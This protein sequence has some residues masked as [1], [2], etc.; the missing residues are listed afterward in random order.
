VD[1]VLITGGVSRPK[2]IRQIEK[3]K[4][5]YDMPGIEDLF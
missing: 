1:N 3:G 2:D 4:V 5:Y